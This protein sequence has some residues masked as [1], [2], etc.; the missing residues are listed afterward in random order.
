MHAYLIAAVLLAPPPT[1]DQE[2]LLPP[3]KQGGVYVIAHR[4]AHNGIPENTLAAYRKAI[5]LGCDFV[6]VDLRM[7]KDGEIV[8]V[9]NATVDAYT[10]NAK[11]P[12]KGFT[13]SELKQMDIGSRVDPKWSDERIPTFR[14]ILDACQKKIGI[15]VDMKQVDIEQA[16]RLV[17]EFEMERNCV[18]YGS[19]GELKQVL[20][21]SP[22][23]R[24]MPDPGPETN[25]ARLL[26]ELNPQVVASVQKFCSEDFVKKCH[27]RGAIVFVDDKSPDDWERFFSW[28]MDGIQTDQP[29]K[30][31]EWLRQKP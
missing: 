11:G 28:K 4:G 20:A 6:E 24:I 19:P 3:P 10:T 18:W 9:H 8:S 21:L 14:E 5:E 31:V 13:L 26:D 29:E 7:T 1:A 16:V 12:V 17:Q 30:L 2:P 22:Q 25:L 27:A 15:Y 23:C